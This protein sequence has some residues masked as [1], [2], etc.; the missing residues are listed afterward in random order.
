LP[1]SYDATFKPVQERPRVL[2]DL[3]AVGDAVLP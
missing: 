1:V 3:L 2:D